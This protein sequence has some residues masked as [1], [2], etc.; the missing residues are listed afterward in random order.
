[1]S[2]TDETAMA[3]GEQLVADTIAHYGIPGMKWGKKKGSS[4]SPG[5]Y[6]K[7]EASNDHRE[8]QNLKRKKASQL[9]NAELKK[10]N[11]RSELTSKYAKNNPGAITKGQA[12]VSAVLA[13]VGTATTI[14]NLVN[15]PMGKA[16]IQAGKDAVNRGKFAVGITKAIT[17]G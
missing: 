3:H 14:Y 6:K 12:K 4:K 10:I 8:V 9:S 11:A 5:A 1:M 15:S 17:S 13:I 7:P 16:T 2:V